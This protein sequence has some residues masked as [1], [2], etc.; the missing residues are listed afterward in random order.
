MNCSTSSNVL[1]FLLYSLSILK[2]NIETQLTMGDNRSVVPL[3]NAI[4]RQMDHGV[5]HA[6]LRFLTALRDNLSDND[7]KNVLGRYSH[8]VQHQAA[9]YTCIYVRAESRHGR[10]SAVDCRFTTFDIVTTDTTFTPID[11]YNTSISVNHEAIL[12]APRDAKQIV[13]LDVCCSNV[14]H[15]I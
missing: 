5:Q 13:R 9:P 10:G 2:C 8:E 6:V 15:A 3:T 11:K 7:M 14:S 12:M 1:H 4:I